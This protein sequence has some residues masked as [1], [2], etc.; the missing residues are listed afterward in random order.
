MSRRIR[1][2]LA[3][4]AVLLVVGTLLGA[5][6][7][8]PGSGGG[9]EPQPKSALPPASKPASGPVVI[10]F[11]GTDPEP[12]TY[13]LPPHMASGQVEQVFVTEGQEVKAGDP[14]FAFDSKL[15]K[16]ELDIAEKGL[17]KIRV[18]VARAKSGLDQY[19]KK[20]DL[21]R[22]VVKAAGRKVDLTAEAYK[23]A[24]TNTRDFIMSSAPMTTP[25]KLQ[26]R[27]ELDPALFKLRVDNETAQSERDLEQAKLA[28]LE[29]ANMKL[30]V[31][32]AEA[33]VAQAQ[34]VVAKAKVAV[35]L[36]TV[37]AKVAGTVE[38]IHVSAGT[39]LGVGTRGTAVALIPSGPRIV[40]A[41][42][43]GDFA[44]R[45]GSDK[46]GKEVT[47]TDH[48]DGKLVYKG[49]VEHIG[50]AFLKKRS[51]GDGLLTSETLVL[52][53]RVVVTDPNPTGKAPLRVGQKVRVNFGP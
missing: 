31:E 22:A 16:A 41:E 47:I 51:G 9:G 5:R 29:A 45:V 19:A 48:T 6:Y 34:A 52:E 7:L 21:Q 43:E 10:G 39:T 28:D 26:E 53:A 13:G 37:R 2:V 4:L 1:P 23:I 18:E 40:R 50:G 15:P 33:G 17:L 11:V 46:K 35:E 49:V 44:H 3:V 24:A 8:S 32:E 14:L 42:I 20:V 38:Q 36:C 30:P 12:A 27:L 25:S